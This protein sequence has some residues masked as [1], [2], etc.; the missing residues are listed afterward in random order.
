MYKTLTL[1][2]LL[3]L[4][5]ALAPQAATLDTLTVVT[6][7]IA[8]PAKAVVVVPDGASERHRAPSVYL[9]NGYSG[10]YRDYASKLDLRALA[11]SFGLVIVCP[12]G[13]DSWY[14]DSPV[15][16]SMQMESYIIH[17][18]IPAVDSRYPTLA[19]AASRGVTGLSMGGHGAFWLASRH[20]RYF[21]AVASMS[22]GLD[23]TPFASRWKI[24]KALGPQKGHP[25][26]WKR[27]SAVN[28][29][30]SIAPGTA[31][32]FDCGE[33]DI[34]IDANRTMHRRLQ[35]LGIPHTFITRPGTHNWAFWTVSLPRHLEFFAKSLKHA[36]D[37]D[38]I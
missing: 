24:A 4:L 10:S 38:D 14:F 7:H 3:A 1:T 13:R 27:C 5:A 36:D 31:I 8:S 29:A 32:Y 21:S 28:R 12:D 15:D 30:D 6:S 34:F 22:G 26:R 2:L 37:T 11:D 33:S 23:L 35:S 20:P 16:P 9:L 17:D 25:A 18:L 19:R